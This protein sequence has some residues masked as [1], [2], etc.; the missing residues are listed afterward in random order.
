MRLP[1]SGGSC[2][3]ARSR[4]R[5]PSCSTRRAGRGRSPK[6][7]SPTTWTSARPDTVEL[8]F[9]GRRPGM[10][11]RQIKNDTACKTKVVTV[12]TEVSMN[13]FFK[14]SRIKQYLKDG[15]ALRI[16]TVVNSP[17]DLNCHRRLQHLSEL[18][19]KARAANARLLD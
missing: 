1:G 16:E 3:C 14:H 7:W 17:D 2:P 4:S 13:A 6:R 10:A 9:T 8:I 18:Q 12:D 15:R 11:G 19:R 5:A